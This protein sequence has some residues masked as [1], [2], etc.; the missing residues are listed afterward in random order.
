MGI[1]DTLS[2]LDEAPPA[3]AST[4]EVATEAAP[5][6]E[7]RSTRTPARTP[8]R[9]DVTDDVVTSLLAGVD[10]SKWRE[11]IGNTETHN[12]AFRLSAAERDAVEDLVRDLRRTKRVKTSMN[13]LARLGLLLLIHDFR[14]RGE[15]SVVFRVKK[16]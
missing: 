16:P 2:Q 9:T 11:L 13:E 1:Y 6:P 14:T 4:K 5:R 15:Q 3:P 8:R 7:R 12:S 10:L